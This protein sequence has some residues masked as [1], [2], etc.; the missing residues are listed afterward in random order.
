MDN[1]ELKQVMRD[2]QWSID[3]L[4]KILLCSKWAVYKYLDGTRTLT[5][6]AVKVLKDEIHG[7]QSGTTRNRSLQRD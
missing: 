3:D 2:Q 5:P 6:L 1:E 4:C 7:I